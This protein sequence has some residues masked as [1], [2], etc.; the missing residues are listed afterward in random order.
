MTSIAGVI[1]LDYFLCFEQQQTGGS[2]HWHT[3]S[4]IN[5]G[6][7]NDGGDIDEWDWRSVSEDN[8]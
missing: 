5:H 4:V 1:S 3:L 2:A 7:A 6:H 8:D